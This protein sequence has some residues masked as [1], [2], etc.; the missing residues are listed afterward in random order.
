MRA[1]SSGSILC[2]A[3]SLAVAFYAGTIL[4]TLSFDDASRRVNDAPSLPV[5]RQAQERPQQP[6]AAQHPP[7][8]ILPLSRQTAD[9]Q[10]V[11][12]SIT[13]AKLSDNNLVTSVENVVVTN[14]NNNNNNTNN[15]ACQGFFSIMVSAFVPGDQQVGL[16]TLLYNSRYRPLLEDHS[17]QMVRMN[18]TLTLFT[19]W[20][21]EQLAEEGCHLNDLPGIRT[22]QFDPIAI[23]RKH[24]FSNDHIQWMEGWHNAAFVAA[25]QK[26]GGLAKTARKILVHKYSARLADIWRVVLAKE[27]R[28]AYADMDMMYLS[29]HPEIYLKDPN[30][31]VPVWGEELGAFEIQNSGF[32]FLPKQLDVLM[33][34]QRE[35]LDAKGPAQAETE[36]YKLYTAMGKYE[37]RMC[38]S[39]CI[40][41][42]S[43]CDVLFVCSFHRPIDSFPYPVHRPKRLSTFHSGNVFSWANPPVL[44]KLQQ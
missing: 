22:Q 39:T 11:T 9:I 21:P 33:R 24:G 4:S 20:T 8:S 28:L 38:A 40:F 16:C 23:L 29:P 34:H 10:T 43:S 12:T 31:A 17:R 18:S 19:T 44:D 42:A 35:I 2:W 6:A 13:T 14:N 7:A 37:K 30:V 32:C 25:K 41:V 1:T 15:F 3:F 5:T 27:H 26:K 36:Q